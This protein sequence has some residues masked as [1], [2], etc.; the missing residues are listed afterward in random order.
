MAT[1]AIG[2]V[3]GC[4][5]PLQSLL[6]QI[7]FSASSDRLWF[8]G[9]LVNRGPQSLEV[10][11]FVKNLGASAVSVLGNHDL[12]LLMVADGQANIHRQDTLGPILDAPDREGLLT[13]LRGLPLMH[14]QDGYAMVHAG[15]LPTWSIPQALALAKETQ[16]ALQ[17]DTWHALMSQMYGNLPDR[18]EESE[19]GHARLRII[20]NA[21][22]RLRVCTADGRMDFN[23]K[24]RVED[25]PAGYMP[26][27]EVPGRLSADTTVV[28]GHWSALG[29]R[30]Q[31]NLLALDTGCVWGGHLSAVRLEDR[32]IF[33][34]AGL[35]PAD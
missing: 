24:G 23:H 32:R 11:R 8:V 33:Q 13:W 16:H 29:L 28:C 2:D 10:L 5:T 34:V 6:A 4:F 21:M 9:D 3:Q 26:W 27:F 12:H 20:I 22:T 15:L 1:Y 31:E 17:A 30:V 7:G 25:I 19:S 18:W 14:A 35:Q